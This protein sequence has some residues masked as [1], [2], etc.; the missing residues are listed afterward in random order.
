MRRTMPTIAV[1]AAIWFFSFVANQV[2]ATGESE[3]WSRTVVKGA[4]TAFTIEHSTALSTGGFL[5]V[6]QTLRGSAFTGV[7]GIGKATFYATL[8]NCSNKASCHK[9]WIVEAVNSFDFPS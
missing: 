9:V 7:E 5:Q 8:I 4:Q 3:S 1:F 2:F 6:T